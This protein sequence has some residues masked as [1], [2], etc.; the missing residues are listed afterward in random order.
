MHTLHILTTNQNGVLLSVVFNTFTTVA[1]SVVGITVVQVS[2]PTPTLNISWQTSQD[3]AVVTGY[4][5]HYNKNGSGGSIDVQHNT[6]LLIPNLVAD[7]QPYNIVV[8]THSIHLSGFSE[9]LQYE[10]CK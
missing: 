4:T 3:G 5:V 1:S 6:T 2:S 10:L 8:E 7:G 9:P